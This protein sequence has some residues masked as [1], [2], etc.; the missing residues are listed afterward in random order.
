MNFKINRMW[1]IIIFGIMM[2]WDVLDSIVPYSQLIL[3]ACTF[4]L[5]VLL[6]KKVYINRKFI[7]ILI[8][9]LL[10][11]IINVF[12][13]KNSFILLTKQILSISICYFTFDALISKISCTRIMEVYFNSAFFV[14]VIG[15]VIQFLN[16]ITGSFYYRMKSIFNEPSFFAY[17]LAPIVCI[18]LF[19]FFYYRKPNTNNKKLEYKLKSSVI[20]VAY[21]CTFSAIAYTGI[22]VIGLLICKEKGFNSKKIII[23]I[24]LLIFVCLAC[25]SVPDIKLRFEETLNAFNGEEIYSKNFSTYTF[26]NNFQVTLNSFK[27]NYG[28]GTGIGSYQ[29]EF[30]KYTL[31]KDQYATFL[32]NLN[33][34]DANSALFRLTTEAGFVGIIFIFYWLNKNFVKKQG[35]FTIY[36]SSMLTILILLLLRQGN[37]IHG[38]TILY[39]CLYEKI[40]NESK[41]RKTVC[42]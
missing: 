3:L 1:L 20:L 25:L 34:E 32:Y 39:I 23:P 41:V 17:F 11:G 12:I 13:G 24:L 16:I 6:N 28:L 37:Y 42:G 14:S 4:L 15:I 30:D 22:I 38:G 40:Y 8:I 18:I 33:R 9:I 2:F 26:Y 31:G 10:Q 27:A 36:S 21:L 35:A 29:I 19:S 7:I 5:Y